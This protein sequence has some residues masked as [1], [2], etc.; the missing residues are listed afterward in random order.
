M[1]FKVGVGYAPHMFGSGP[2]SWYTHRLGIHLEYW[3]PT[4]EAN[5]PFDRI[6][7]NLNNDLLKHR[8]SAPYRRRVI[9]DV[10]IMYS[11]GI[12]LARIHVFPATEENLSYL[13]W[14]ASVCRDHKVELMV[15]L[16]KE[17][18][19]H[20]CQVDP[21]MCAV[22]AK[23]LRG[24][25]AVWQLMNETNDAFATNPESLVPVF[26]EA[27]DEIR[28]ADPDALICL[29]NARFDPE[30]TEHF[31]SAGAPID[32]LG[33]D[34]YP[35]SI[36]S[37]SATEDVNK[38]LIN[39]CGKLRSFHE[40]HPDIEIA[41][42]EFGIHPRERVRYSTS[43]LELHGHLFEEY[44]RTVLREAGD[45]LFA[46]IPFWFQDLLVFR[47]GCYHQL[48]NLD[49]TLTPLGESYMNIVREYTA[50]QISLEDMP[51]IRR[52]HLDFDQDSPLTDE[53]QYYPSVKDVGDCLKELRS[54]L[55]V[56][57]DDLSPNFYECGMFMAKTLSFFLK[58]Q[59]KVRT[60]T[61]VQSG[62]GNGTPSILIGNRHTNPI[63]HDTDLDRLRK[64]RQGRAS[65]V[66]LDGRNVLVLDGSDD[67]GA[68]AVTL[69]LVRRYWKI[70]NSLSPEFN[71][72]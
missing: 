20:W 18:P 31:I 41:I 72:Q 6:P 69:D 45:F 4:N 64:P 47:T 62:K 39:E 17:R 48:V 7:F 15:D 26:K 66:H 14:L 46:F 61:E 35:P 10:Q 44:A 24:K 22:Y 71:F 53:V 58:N 3:S 55:I 8:D 52:G 54:P 12:R 2:N 11:M 9:N 38:G 57:G 63:L 32:V 42:D 50:N 29:N 67:D 27:A 43:R 51:E 49:R 56:V 59:P 33:V 60:A 34:Y 5:Y 70:E 25:V 30:Y 65:L 19:E 23:T 37:I 28:K 36:R 1:N 21:K 13:K 68:I 16:V 40:K